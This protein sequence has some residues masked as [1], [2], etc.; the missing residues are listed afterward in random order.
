MNQDRP[1]F[2][3]KSSNNA[4]VISEDKASPKSAGRRTF[5]AA[6]ATAYVAAIAAP[7]I[8][9]PGK[10]YAAEANQQKYDEF[11][12]LSRFV[13]GH[14]DISWET[15]RRFFDSLAHHDADFE[16][17]VTAL[18]QHLRSKGYESFDAFLA[19]GESDA[20]LHA[21]ATTVVSAWY[22]GVVGEAANAELITFADSL[23]YRPTH[24]ILAVPTYGPGPLA[25]GAR[26]PSA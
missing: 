5:M 10:V 24:G 9:L 22:L 7:S 25:W 18:A 14:K 11:F 2:D 26:P 13:T 1:G 21:T 8:F 15:S 19:D 3:D 16:S 6:A 20:G 12:S 23:M 17:K 4:F